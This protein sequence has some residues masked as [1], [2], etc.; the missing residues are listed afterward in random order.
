MTL[1][2][3][4]PPVNIALPL[5]AWADAREPRICR[6]VP[7]ATRIISARHA[8]SLDRAT[9]VCELAGIGQDVQP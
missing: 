2:K 3:H 9:L 6:P 5:F 1:P 8:L 4:H 7:V